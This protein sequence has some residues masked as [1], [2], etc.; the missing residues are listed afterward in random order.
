[1]QQAKPNQF[2]FRIP[3][4]LKPPSSQIPAI[5]KFINEND[6]LAIGIYHHENTKYDWSAYYFSIAAANA[7]PT[8]IFLYAISMRHGWGMEQNELE[9]FQLLSQCTDIYEDMLAKNANIPTHLPLYY[10]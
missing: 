7:D 10:Y 9:A 2:K 3:S 6:P 5:P 8:G 1:M 4:K